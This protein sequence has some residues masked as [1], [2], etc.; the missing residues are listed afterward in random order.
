M[1][2]VQIGAQQGKLFAGGFGLHFG[3]HQIVAAFQDA[4]LVAAGGELVCLDAH[5]HA[6][7]AAFTGRTIGDGLAAAKTGMGQ[8]FGQ[9]LGQ[10]AAQPGEDLALDAAGQIGAGPA[11]RQEELGYACVAL[12]RHVS[13]PARS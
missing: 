13:K 3:T 12:V 11:R 5:G 8:G 4:F 7:A 9:G 2:R 10:V 6:G 1:A